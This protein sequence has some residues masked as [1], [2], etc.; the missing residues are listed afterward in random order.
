[1]KNLSL[2]S[3]AII[4]IAVFNSCDQAAEITGLGNLADGYSEELKSNDES[5]AYQ[6]DFG[7]ADANGSAKNIASISRKSTLLRTNIKNS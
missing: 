5:L 4:F 1:M 3:L 2:V 6:W 7:D